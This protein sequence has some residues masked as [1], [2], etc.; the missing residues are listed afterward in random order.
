M[1][2]RVGDKK[3]TVRWNGRLDGQPDSAEWMGVEWDSPEEG[4]HD[5]TYEGKRYFTPI[6]NSN[7]CSFIRKRSVDQV[8][9]VSCLTE[10][11]GN[12]LFES[13]SLFST[14]ISCCSLNEVSN[15]S[16]VRELDL[17]DTLI[18]SLQVLQRI[19]SKFPFLEIL[20]LNKIRLNLDEVECSFPSIKTLSLC[21]SL[22]DSAAFL[23]L[24][25]NLVTLNLSKV[26]IKSSLLFA[27]PTSIRELH[28]EGCGLTEFHLPNRSF[29][30]LNLNN[31][32]MESLSFSTANI[33]YIENN[34]IS[35]WESLFIEPKPKIR[36]I[37]V[38]GNE[39]YFNW[40]LLLPSVELV[41][42][43]QFERLKPLAA[44]PINEMTV[45]FSF[46]SA[47]SDNFLIGKNVSLDKIFTYIIRKYKIPVKKKMI[48]QVNEQSVVFPNWQISYPPN[49]EFIFIKYDGSN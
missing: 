36:S 26:P 32:R 13:I 43:S 1:R 47:K 19:I 11:Y 39:K 45:E 29:D 17:S 23:A 14:N 5:G 37:Y 10:K 22:I 21:S 35:N 48:F 6:F 28:L 41:N 15:A 33:L 9:F 7:S 25:P 2:I 46:N 3:G 42:G 40:H 18:D 30:L 31:N 20:R 4:K 12:K 44:P 38:H 34:Q 49:E 24:F 16:I 27:L 8:E